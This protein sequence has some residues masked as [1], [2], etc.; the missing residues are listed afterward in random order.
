MAPFASR[1][2]PIAIV[3]DVLSASVGLPVNGAGRF[4]F[5]RENRSSDLIVT[6]KK[7]MSSN[8]TSIIG[9]MSRAGFSCGFLAMLFSLQAKEV[10]TPGTPRLRSPV[11]ADRHERDL[12][13]SGG[14][15]GVHHARDNLVPAV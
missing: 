2:R 12:P 14:R 5:R 11:L 9:V 1:P 15:D 6:T 13:D 7:M 10:R 4:A 3:T 8:T